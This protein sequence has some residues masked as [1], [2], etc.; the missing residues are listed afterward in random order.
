MLTVKYEPKKTKELRGIILESLEDRPEIERL[1]ITDLVYCPLK[2]YN[3]IALKLETKPTNRTLM[4]WLIGRVF[5]QLVHQAFEIKEK[6]VELFDIVGYLDV[7]HEDLPIEIKTTRKRILFPK[8]IPEVYLKQLSYYMLALTV[9]HGY[10]LILDIVR[11]AF[12]VWHVQIPYESIN[13]LAYDFTSKASMI[14][15]AIESRDISRLKRVTWECRGCPY[16][17]QNGCSKRV[18]WK[19]HYRKSIMM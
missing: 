15:H 10:L 14:K 2:A 12:S 5:H 1:H 9:N 3:R 17:Y 6:R 18:T 16:N 19:Q 11:P 7:L 8:D 13:G 4:Y